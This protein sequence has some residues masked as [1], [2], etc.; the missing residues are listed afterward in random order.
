MLDKCETLAGKSLATELLPLGVDTALFRPGYLQEAQAW[1]HRLSIP[2]QAHVFLSVRALHPR[3]GQ[4]DILEAFAQAVP[5]FPCPPV[6][7]FKRYNNRGVEAY[8]Q[9]LRRRAAELGLAEHVRWV[10]GVDFQELPALYAAADTVVNYPAIDGF[11]VTF[12]EAA[13]CERPVVS[14]RLPS[15]LGTFA[16][17]YFRLVEPG[18][19]VAFAA[20]L[21]EAALQPESERA[22]TTREARSVVEREYDESL[23]AARLLEI[24]GR[25]GRASATPLTASVAGS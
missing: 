20:A 8:E 22:R 1:R 23:T 2:E 12:L 25:L 15:Y 19:R 6:M 14:N 17:R 5:R 3:Y 9:Q 21:I 16:E 24:Y 11:P 4:L 13:A 10:D 7:L 18:D